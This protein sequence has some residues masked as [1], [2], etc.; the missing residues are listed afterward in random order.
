MLFGPE[1]STEVIKTGVQAAAGEKVLRWM[2]LVSLVL[3]LQAVVTWLGTASGLWGKGLLRC[4]DVQDNALPEP[5][6]GGPAV[7]KT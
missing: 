1:M 6:M 5:E 2:P 3:D 4:Y 7:I